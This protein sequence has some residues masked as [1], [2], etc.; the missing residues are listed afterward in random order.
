M[1][2]LS[3]SLAL[4]RRPGKPRRSRCRPTME[5]LE[6]RCTPSTLGGINLGSLTDYGFVFTN[7][8]QDAN[9]QGATK[10][11][12]G[13]VAVNGG[14][15]FRTSGGVPFAGTI[16]TDGPSIGQWQNIVNQNPGQ[17]HVSTGNTGLITTLA[18]SLNAAFTQING[19]AATPGYTSVSSTSLDGLDTTTLDGVGHT[20]VINITSSLQVSSKIDITGNPG[21]VFVLR[22][23]SD[24]NYS[25]GYQGLVKF[26]SGGAI[27]PHGGLTPANFI[28]VAGDI[29]SSG[30]GSNPATPYPQ[31]PRLDNGTGALINGG[32]NFSG[33]G[34]F[35]GYWLTTGDPSNGQTHALSNAIFAGGWY[36]TTNKFSMTSG[37]SGV[38]VA[39][40]PATTAA[41]SSLSGHVYLDFNKNRVR[42]NGEG[43]V[44]GA[45]VTLTGIDSQGHL[46]NQTVQIDDNGFYQFTN[47]LPGTYTLTVTASGF[48]V[49]LS[50]VGTVNNMPDGTQGLG[51]TTGITLLAGDDGVDYDFGAY[52]GE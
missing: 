21:D 49:E 28:N 4:F 50:N 1:N 13:D 2:W 30:G 43:A 11:F 16:Y 17:A 5:L 29:S 34:F 12:A 22:W 24:A 20:Y 32:S 9:W 33:G 39:P 25:N 10:G 8:S 26:Q 40:N 23:D 36:T 37:T 47:L 27:V 48:H 35:T 15:H 46:V 14:A 52:L 31:G 3:R 45:S 42:E 38:Y 51:I 41:L 18:D 6:D 44:V 19:L 7:A